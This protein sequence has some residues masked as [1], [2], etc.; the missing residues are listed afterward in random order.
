MTSPESTCAIC[1]D[2]I[3][4][5]DPQTTRCP[6]C[7]AL[8]HQDC[9]QHNGGCAI[10][11]C[12]SVP[13]LEKQPD[14][15]QPLSHWG[16]DS[17]SCPKCEATIQVTARRCRHCGYMF[18]SSTPDDPEKPASEPTTEW[19]IGAIRRRIPWLCAFCL[20]PVTAAP[21]ALFGY[22]WYRENRSVMARM[23]ASYSAACR[24]SLWVAA[25]QTALLSL[26]LAVAMIGGGLE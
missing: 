24:I 9:W 11:G 10:Y 2:Q 5:D 8:Y 6:D 22:F 25:G 3:L 21:A 13:E 12:P 18:A 26:V 17:K 1:Q 4:P 7:S 15:E 23:P 20:F 16:R 14:I 19:R